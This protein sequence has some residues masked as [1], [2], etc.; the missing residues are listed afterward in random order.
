MGN[1]N[2]GGGGSMAAVQNQLFNIKFTAKQI[3]RMSKK[4]DHMHACAIA[5][6][7]MARINASAGR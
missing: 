5:T 6:I 7:K 3:H 4:C 1:E 2:S